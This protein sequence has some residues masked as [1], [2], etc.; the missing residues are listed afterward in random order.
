MDALTV[1]FNTFYTS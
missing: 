1:R